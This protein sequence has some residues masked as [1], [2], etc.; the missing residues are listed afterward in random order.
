MSWFALHSAPT[1]FAKTLMVSSFASSEGFQ[2]QITRN[3][4][5]KIYIV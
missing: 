5:K 3:P 4:S 1:I 2:K